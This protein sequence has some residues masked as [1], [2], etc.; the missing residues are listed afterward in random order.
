MKTTDFIERAALGAAAGLVGTLGI[1]VLRAANQKLIPETMPPIRQ[2]PGEFM[3]DKAG[4]MLP[5]ETRAEIPETVETAAA[6]SLAMGYG[7]AAGALYGALNSGSRNALVGGVLLGLGTW[8]IGYLGWLPASGLM[9][10]VTEHT[11]EQVALSVAQHAVFG[12]VTAA[13]YQ[14][15]R[16]R[17]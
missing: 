16:R 13:L 14:W 12:F 11:R 3:V 4:E 2:D 6:K 7:M 8:A 10:P 9:P 1:Q 15:L 17:A 5:D